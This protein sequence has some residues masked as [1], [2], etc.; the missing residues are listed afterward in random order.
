MSARWSSRRTPPQPSPRL[1]G[2]EVSTP[3]LNGLECQDEAFDSQGKRQIQPRTDVSWKRMA[4][5]GKWTPVAAPFVVETLAWEGL[6]Y[7][8]RTR[9]KGHEIAAVKDA[10]GLVQRGDMVAVMGTWFDARAS[11]GGST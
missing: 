2:E 1:D 4:K 5:E 7:Y 3:T 10:T 6:S 9:D 11:G 8:Y